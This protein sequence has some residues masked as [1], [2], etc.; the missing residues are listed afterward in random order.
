MNE[1][2]FSIDARVKPGQAKSIPRMT[3]KD[4]GR[5]YYAPSHSAL[6]SLRKG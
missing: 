4:N 3:I 6:S 5:W 1:G 2:L